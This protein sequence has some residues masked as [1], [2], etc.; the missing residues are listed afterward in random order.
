M[1]GLCGLTVSGQTSWTGLRTHTQ[2]EILLEHP[3]TCEDVSDSEA[4]KGRVTMLV[5]AGWW[6]WWLV[7]VVTE[8][9]SLL[10]R[11]QRPGRRI[12]VPWQG[13]TPAP[14]ADTNTHSDQATPGNRAEA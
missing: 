12:A 14:L 9:R 10:D 13:L 6:W 11:T 5:E 4:V 7:L 8:L 1:S 3:G 2:R